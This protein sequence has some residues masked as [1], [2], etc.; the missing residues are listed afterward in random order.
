MPAPQMPSSIKFHY[1]KSNLYRVIHLDGAIGGLTASREI[2]ISLFND[3]GTLPKMIEF[4]VTPDGQL[5]NE[6]TREGKEGLVREMEVGVLM[7]AAAAKSLAA[8]LI[9]QA[10]LLEESVPET[11]NDSLSTKKE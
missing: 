3:R 11:R 10:K 7:N 6:I 2:F 9:T 4:A 1:I 8:Y 5:G